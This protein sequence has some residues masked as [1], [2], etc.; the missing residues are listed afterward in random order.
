MVW[1]GVWLETRYD[2]DSTS[3]AHVH[4]LS[5]VSWFSKSRAAG[6]RWMRSNM[7]ARIEGTDT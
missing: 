7:A 6:V 5:A 4:R 3:G 2:F 1:L